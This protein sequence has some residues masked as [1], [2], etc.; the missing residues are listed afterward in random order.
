MSG[1]ENKIIIAVIKV[2][3]ASQISKV[4]RYFYLIVIIYKILSCSVIK[5]YSFKINR[6]FLIM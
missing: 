3:R 5:V 1:N 6:Y 2:K 4:L